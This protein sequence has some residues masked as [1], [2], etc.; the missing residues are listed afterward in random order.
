MQFALPENLR[1]AVA[2]YD[3]VLKAAL[4]AEK[5]AKTKHASSSAPLG[6][7]ENLFPVEIMPAAMQAELVKELNSKTAE[8]RHAVVNRPLADCVLLHHRSV[9]LAAWVPTSDEA[10]YLYGFKCMWKSAASVHNKVDDFTLRRNDWRQGMKAIFTEV[11]YGRT[12]FN[13]YSKTIKYDNITDGETQ[14]PWQCLIDRWSK[15]SDEKWNIANRVLTKKLAS[16]LPQWEDG[17]GVFD[18]YM[19]QNSPSRI[20][21]DDNYTNAEWNEETIINRLAL[22]KE[23]LNTPFFRR[24][25]MRVMNEVK[26]KALDPEVI[27]R[28]AVQKPWKYLQHQCNF[29]KYFIN[30]YD[31]A[32]LDYI[33]QMYEI[34]RHCDPIQ[35]LSDACIRWIKAN[36]PI[37]SWVKL[38]STFA[39]SNTENIPYSSFHF[40]STCRFGELCDTLNMLETVLRSKSNRIE[41]VGRPDRWRITE[42]HDYF[43]AESFKANNTNEP[44]PQDL[45]PEPVKV[46]HLGSRWTFFQPRDVHQLAQWGSAVRNCVGAASNYRDGIKKQT[47]F[48]VL[49]M[50]DNRPRFTVQ[51]KVANGMMDVIQ[52]AGIGNKP[53]TSEERSSYEITFAAALQQRAQ[54]LRKVQP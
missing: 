46:D 3:P 5:R 53:L 22:K 36:I 15:H 10:D 23:I 52:V 6:L 39:E 37:A 43:T 18:R 25:I 21:F 28:R 50:I 24:E 32:S 33:Q 4:L 26:T 35:Y 19:Y 44:L 7:P 14:L 9:W 54:S 27:S 38:F 20:A 47:H 31:D 12:M 8:N 34:G 16:R 11:K 45:F 49:A 2:Q 1:Q 41:D 42:F 48:I 40:I 13:E 17:S 30:L 51:L 29:V